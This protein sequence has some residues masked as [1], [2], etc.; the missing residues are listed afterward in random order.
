MKTIFEKAHLNVIA[1]NLK[2]P[3]LN[4]LITKQCLGKNN[5]RQQAPVLPEVS[6]LDLV[7]HFTGLSKRNSGIDNVFYPL[8]SCTMKYNPRI[9]EEMASLPG[10]ASLHPQTPEDMSQGNLQILYETEEMLSEITGMDAF[11]LQPAAGAQGEL[12]GIMLIQ[13]YH[14]DNEPGHHRHKILIP[15]SAHGTNPASASLCG[16]DCVTI[17]S[18]ENGGV[19]IE[20]LKANLDENVAGLMLTNPNTAGL[21]D[22]NILTISKLVH[23]VGGLL[24]YDGANLNAVLGKC[25]PGDMGFD[26]I[27]CE[28]SQDMHDTSWWWRSRIWSC[29]S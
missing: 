29:W 21:F 19:D 15:D 26:V 28:S 3:N 8:G 5:I 6:E 14:N 7:R 20:D 4:R 25:R 1:S 10:F 2:I 13:A 11:T 24:Y 16:F 18:D 27:R 12:V 17:K 23:E 9:H 22:K